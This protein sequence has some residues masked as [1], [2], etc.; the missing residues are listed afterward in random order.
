[1]LEKPEEFIKRLQEAL[2]YIEAENNNDV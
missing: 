1:M 2:E